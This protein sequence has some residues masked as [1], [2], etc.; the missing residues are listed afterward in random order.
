MKQRTRWLAAVLTFTMLIMSL[1]ALGLP[2]Q[3]GAVPIPQSFAKGADVSW[4]PQMEAEGHKFYNDQG[5]EA[6]LLQILKDHG[7]DSIRLRAFVDPSDDPINGHNSTEEMVQLASRVSAL[8]FRVMVDLHYSDSWADPGKQVT[9]AAWASD[10][11]EQL[12]A[13]VSEYTTEVMQALKT[14]G[15]TPEW[16][17]IGNE[18]NNGMMHPLGSYSNTANLVELIQAGS[19]AAKAVFPETKIIIHRANGAD[20]GV[21]PFYAGL[22]EAGL[23]DSDYDIIGLSYYPDSIYTSSINELS[24]N[25]NLLAAKYGKE[26]MVVEVGGDVSK[27]VDNV[28]NMLVAVQNGVKAVPGGKGTGV[29][30]WAPEGVYFGYGLSAWNPDGKP[31]FAMDAFIEGASAINRVPVQSVKV[32]KQAAILEVGGTG[33]VKA[34]ISPGN[35]TYKGLT[36][37]SS[38]EA[39]VKVDKYKGTISGLAAGTST[40][41]A[42]TYDGGFTDSTEITVSPS[43]SFIQNPGFEDGLNGWSVSG[44]S[45]AVNVESDAHS[46]SAALHYWSSGAAEFQVSQT[47]TGLEN[48]TYQLSA[49]VSGGGGE[50]TA[51]I[52]AG[53]QKQAFVNTG[54]QQWSNPTIDTVEVT[55]GTLTLGA[56]LKYA[57]DKWGNIDDF[58][59]IKKAGAVSTNN[60]TVNGA[61][62]D[63]YLSGTKPATFG[64]SNASGGFDYGD[65]KPVNFNLTHEINGLEPGTY[66]LQAKIFGDKGEPSPGS[67]MYVIS[68]G[69]TYSVPVTYSGS[70]W[71]KPRTLTLKHV[72]IGEDGSASL[73]FKVITDSDNHYGYLQE[74][75]F[76]RNSTTAPEV[77][78]EPGTPPTTEPETPPTTEPGTPPV[79]EPV[80][81]PVTEPVTPPEENPAP[82]AEASP[83]PSPTAAPG[84]GYG[85][86]WTAPLATAQASATPPATP[87]PEIL[88]VTEPKVNAQNQI[89]IPMA[90]GQSVVRIPAD[91]AALKGIAALKV[92]GKTVTAEIPGKVVQQLQ[93][94]AG[95][96]AKGSMI[97]V[98]LTPWS[99][100]QKAAWT[101]QAKTKNEAELRTAGEMFN[102]NLSV[103]N[104]Q[105]VKTPLASFT[106]PVK[107]R[108][109]LQANGN[110]KLAG[111]YAVA[112]D[113]TLKY[114]GGTTEQS[115][116][117]S[118]VR[119]SGNYALLE[120]DKSFADVSPADWAYSVIKEMAAKHIIEGDREGRFAP[121]REVT[122][123]EFVTMLVRALGLKAEGMSSFADVDSSKWYS[124]DVAAAFAAGIVKGDA[125]GKFAPESRITRQEM[126]A[127]FVRAYEL[128][129]GSP[130]PADSLPAFADA[131]QI[132]RWAKEAVSA[133]GSLGII[134]GTPDGFLKPQANATRAECAKVLSL[135]LNL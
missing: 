72:H 55:D 45:A 26:V 20:S 104:Q 73:G 52:F 87:Q 80:T 38:D 107:L 94:L 57:G 99:A 66:T 30:Y 84:T 121:K 58:K 14:A 100:E 81:P 53:N 88:T 4:L 23:K 95:S 3:A 43:T 54:W 124:G 48:G 69:Q 116:L 85:S 1:T 49:W 25:M 102:L 5:D 77:P 114:V 24:S 59:L 28:Y 93:A 119:Q 106:E 74:V 79:T 112:D 103:L 47:V 10:N 62:S 135:L 111:V 126:A 117:T 50:E 46:G 108:L 83:A 133:A 130:A 92:E 113:G 15:V 122:R 125:T 127:L 131:E 89:V 29:F 115:V 86:G 22:V 2:A 9:P 129:S 91:A 36:F 37:T 32:E 27:N 123:A 17:Q 34:T 132:D 60:L 65:D 98:G 33:S 118:Q 16:V 70:A 128:R 109:K 8:G 68:E 78:S 35:A 105:G 19:H 96:S 41:T 67:V 18:I 40:V 75:T 82:S 7:I 44:D 11:L 110:P 42:V 21:D 101:L 51:E 12:K 90:E 120:Y 31:S 134:T 64:D 71:L 6:D 39:I 63:W 76:V 97:S 56:N 61:K 13:H